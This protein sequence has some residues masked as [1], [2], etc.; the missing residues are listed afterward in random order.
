MVSE[1]LILAVPVVLLALGC[2]GLALDEKR[3]KTRARAAARPVPVR[4]RTTLPPLPPVLDPRAARAAR[5]ARH[6]SAR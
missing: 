2:L 5:A 4:L 3:W 1:A 6:R